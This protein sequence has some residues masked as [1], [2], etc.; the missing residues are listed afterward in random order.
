MC[1]HPRL[2]I[3]NLSN[4][5]HHDVRVRV[6]PRVPSLFPIPERERG[7]YCRR[8]ARGGFFA[9]GWSSRKEKSGSEE[10]TVREGGLD[11]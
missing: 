11:R 2:G 10:P 1:N 9:A 8:K 5:L 3:S 7:Q 4:S 6:G